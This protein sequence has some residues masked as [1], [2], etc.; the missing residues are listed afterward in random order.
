MLT[1]VAPLTEINNHQGARHP[2]GTDPSAFNSDFGEFS[3]LL[4]KY[5]V[6]DDEVLPVYGESFDDLVSCS[7]EAEHEI[8]PEPIETHLTIEEVEETIEEAVQGYKEKWRVTKLPLRKSMARGMW[9]TSRSVGIQ[10]CLITDTDRDIERLDH[11]LTKYRKEIAEHTWE[12]QKAL[13]DQCSI[14][15][16]T[17]S[18]LEDALWRHSVYNLETEPPEV[19]RPA[20]RPRP[21]KVH[22]HEDSVSVSSGEEELVGGNISLQD[23]EELGVIGEEQEDEEWDEEEKD[24]EVAVNGEGYIYLH[25]SISS[26]IKPHQIDGV[27]FLWREIVTTGNESQG[28]LLAHTM[29]LGKTMQTITLLTTIAEAANSRDPKIRNQIPIHLRTSRT[30]IICPSS[31]ITNWT[32]ELDKWTTPELKL[33]LGFTHTARPDRS[34]RERLQAIE[35]WGGEQGGILLISFDIF[36][37]LIHNKSLRKKPPPLTEAQHDN[38][39]MWLLESPSLIVID[40]AHKIKNDTTEIAKAVAR[41]GLGGSKQSRIAL[42]GTPLSNNLLEYFQMINW[43]HPKFLGTKEEFGTMYANII[44][45]GLWADSTPYQYRRSLKWLRLFGNEIAPKVHRADLSVIK[46]ELKPKTEFLITLPLTDVQLQAYQAFIDGQLSGTGAIKMHNIFNW[47]KWLTLLWNAPAIFFSKLESL[48]ESNFKAKPRRGTRTGLITGIDGERRSASPRNGD[49]SLS[50][51]GLSKH[52][53]NEQRQ[54]YGQWKKDRSALDLSY[55]IQVLEKILHYC[56]WIGDQVL[57]FSHSVLTLDHLEA[58]FKRDGRSYQRLD[59]KTP[60]GDRQDHVDTFNEGYT[61]IYL[62]ST[63]AGGLGLNL[64]GANRVVVMDFEYNPQDIEQAIG[65]SYRIGQKKPVFVY[66]LLTGGATESRM[67][68]NSLF[69]KHLAVTVVDKKNVIRKAVMVLRDYLNPAEPVPQ[70]DLDPYLGKDPDVLDKVLN[71]DQTKCQIRS[72]DLI[73]FHEDLTANLT[74]E[75]LKEVAEMKVNFRRTR[76]EEHLRDQRERLWKQLSLNMQ[77]THAAPCPSEDVRRDRSSFGHLT[78]FPDLLRP[79]EKIPRP[80]SFSSAANP[81]FVVPNNR[82]VYRGG[83][84]GQDDKD[85]ETWEPRGTL[86]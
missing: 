26:R 64:I 50:G 81:N 42:T 53:I 34:F 30:L 82:H 24:K 54:L 85:E 41:F 8:E 4:D 25:N 68:N 72:I 17:V 61:N 46:D 38:V 84:E 33:L 80:R 40:E 28:C 63:K 35:D 78:L 45:E 3:Y 77:A 70:D 55:K 23:I 27:R 37:R 48:E 51:E 86:M 7:P 29:G 49:D 67:F 14:L 12:S 76:E 31:L 62:I 44:N 58:M 18:D 65:R 83:P 79:N 15:D 71:N 5:T 11:R 10:R 32:E 69:K 60:V 20:T 36:R 1:T 73:E 66:H 6:E 19:A 21:A 43:V 39:K 16:V 59:G 2:T 75:E 47:S 13:L 52:M 57:I 74:P 22:D 56:K 9:I